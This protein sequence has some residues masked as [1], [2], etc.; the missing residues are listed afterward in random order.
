MNEARRTGAGAAIIDL[1]WRVEPQNLANC[2]LHVT[3]SSGSVRLRRMRLCLATQ[4]ERGWD[5]GSW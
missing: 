4:S 3:E 1:T 5:C 2:E